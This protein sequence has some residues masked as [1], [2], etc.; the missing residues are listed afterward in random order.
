MNV[1]LSCIGKRGYIA[2]YFREC[3]TDE[4]RIIG[5]SNTR[6]TPGFAKCDA[7]YVLPSIDDQTYPDAV[8]GVCRR[9]QVDI[10]LSLYDPD[11]VR[12]SKYRASFLAA[13]TFPL[14]PDAV[15]ADLA[16]D[17]LETFK[18]LTS[19]GIRTPRTFATFTD[20]NEAVLQEVIQLPLFVK[21]R[22]GFG[23]HL[24][25][26][27][28]TLQQLAAFM[29]LGVD[30]IAQ[31]CISGRM[32]NVDAFA[33][34]N[35]AVVSIV[36]WERHLSVYGETERAETIECPDAI[37]VAKLALEQ[38]AFMGPADVDMFIDEAG[39]V[40]IL[41][42]NIRFGGGYPVSHLAG[43]DFPAKAVSVARGQ[44]LLPCVGHY[45]RGIFMTKGLEILGG[46]GDELFD[47]IL[48]VD[49]AAH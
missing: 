7:G 5:T 8:L 41:E 31:E 45:R 32:V 38:L 13:G 25:F 28:E 6:W 37:E 9:E 18:F 20:A 30:M 47:G 39:D 26:R 17:K 35:G 42:F 4:D 48:H 2:D 3:L 46:S 16:F 27:C 10:L 40:G 33:D 43:A 34:E 1:L 23:S 15:S 19:L 14:I 29:S 49:A 36:P 21:P 44:P 22:R 11:V 24:T 12:L